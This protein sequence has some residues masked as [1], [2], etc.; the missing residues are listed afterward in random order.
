MVTSTKDDTV[1]EEAE[2]GDA[3]Q[4]LPALAAAAALLLEVLFA[5]VVV[6]VA[7]DVHAPPEGAAIEE[8]N[9]MLGMPASNAPSIASPSQ[10]LAPVVMHK[11]NTTNST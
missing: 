6:A 2:G 11:N 3:G 7:A 9:W 5:A 1:A 8:E 10:A 4:A